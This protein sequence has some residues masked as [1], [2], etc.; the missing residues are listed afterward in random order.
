MKKYFIIFM[1][2]GLLFG[3]EKDSGRTYNNP[4]LPN[5]SFSATINLNLPGYSGLNSNSNP[6]MFT[7]DGDINIVMMKVAGTD[8]RA[9]NGNCP[10]Q[11]P[12]ACSKLSIQG[13]SAKC[14]CEDG[15]AYSLFDGTAAAQYGMI[16][17][18]VEVLN[19]STI[20]VYN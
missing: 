17:Y 9:W 5:Y 12:T 15:Y 11:A 10:N 8:Y 1:V 14:N 2:I 7:V 6:I 20:R 3:C 16:P 4:Y 19:S 18:R 13:L